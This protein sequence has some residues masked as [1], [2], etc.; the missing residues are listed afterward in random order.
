MGNGCGSYLHQIAA[1]NQT[2]SDLHI[3][4]PIIDAN[5]GFGMCAAF[6]DIYTDYGQYIHRS[7]IALLTQG[8]MLC[9]IGRVE[10]ALYWVGTF[11]QG[12]NSFPSL[13]R[14][15]TEEVNPWFKVCA[16]AST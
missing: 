1:S 13:C 6:A 15:T 12:V 3:N 5:I 14:S 2:T 4:L 9:I 8:N 11:E 16:L 7:P 10:H